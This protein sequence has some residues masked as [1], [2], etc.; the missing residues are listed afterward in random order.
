MNNTT[1]TKE[2]LANNGS[3]DNNDKLKTNIDNIRK[4]T[5]R[6]K[7]VKTKSKGLISSID[8]F[9]GIF[10]PIQGYEGLYY[11]TKDGRVYSSIQ[12]K[13]LKPI[14]NNNG[15]PTVNLQGQKK[16]IHRLIAE[17]FIPNPDNL[18]VV[19]HKDE[20][21]LNF[22]ID[23]LEWCTYK[24]NNNYGTAIE[25][26]RKTKASQRKIKKPEL[27]ANIINILELND[28]QKRLLRN[29]FQQIR[30]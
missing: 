27:L 20:N 23:N 12:N 14:I 9:D 1:N 3:L 21:K 11:I 17:S 8:G 6:K 10:K 2:P 19:N 4:K 13:W 15:Y 30:L 26:T 24:Y 29:Y 28:A 18:P 16:L 5:G 7:G 25:R 22:S